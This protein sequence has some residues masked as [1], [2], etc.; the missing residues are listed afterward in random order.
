MAIEAVNNLENAAVGGRY[1]E[2]ASPVVPAS[3][4]VSY[5]CEKVS[6]I[7]KYGHYHA[8]WRLLLLLVLDIY[9]WEV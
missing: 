2:V 9:L 4:P 5:Y 3:A 6:S 7:P 8:S 1:A